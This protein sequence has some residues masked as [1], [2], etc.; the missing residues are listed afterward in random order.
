MAA[1]FS[2]N[3][4]LTI[5]VPEGCTIPTSGGVS[6]VSYSGI[7]APYGFPAQRGKWALSLSI[8]SP[9]NTSGTVANTIY[10]PGGINLNIPIGEWSFRAELTVEVT[11]SATAY[12]VVAGASTSASSFSDATL[13]TRLLIQ[14]ANSSTINY[15]PYSRSGNLSC[16]VATPVYV[17]FKSSGA[18]TTGQISGASD[19]THASLLS[20]EN[21]YL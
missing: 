18:F 13:A 4:T 15:A 8:L 16:A 10:N 19:G 20:A 5:Q 17:L 7:K 6:A 9:V 3:T 2:T 14:Q 21:A 1:T 11:S 12:D